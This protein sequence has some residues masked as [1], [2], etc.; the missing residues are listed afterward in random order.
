MRYFF[1]PGLGS[2]QTFRIMAN[3]TYELFIFVQIT[4]VCVDGWVRVTYL[5]RLCLGVSVIFSG[6]APRSLGAVGTYN[7]S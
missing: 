5:T 2:D 4:R 6:V 3:F 1:L 7:M